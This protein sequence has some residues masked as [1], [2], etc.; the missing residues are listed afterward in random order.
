MKNKT[1]SKSGHIYDVS[2]L[3]FQRTLQV[4]STDGSVLAYR[5]AAPGS[6]LGQGVSKFLS[7]L[8]LPRDLSIAIAQLRV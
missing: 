1:R 2:Q 3:I 4:H 8:M 6:I 5:L 7:F